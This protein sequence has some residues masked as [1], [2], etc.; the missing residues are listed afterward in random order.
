VLAYAGCRHFRSWIEQQFTYNEDGSRHQLGQG[1]GTRYEACILADAAS[2]D[3][4]LALALPGQPGHNLLDHS[5]YVIIVDA[6]Y[7]PNEGYDSPTYEGWMK[8]SAQHI[9]VLYDLIWN[10][11]VHPWYTGPEERVWRD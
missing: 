8:A 10:V 9:G 6:F 4:V 1:D 11:G 5:G 2:I 3:S 7:D